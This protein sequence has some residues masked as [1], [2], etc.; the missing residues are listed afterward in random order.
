MTFAWPQALVALLFIPLGL[1]AYRALDRRQRRKV[2]A[3]GGSGAFGPQGAPAAPATPAG[4]PRP[5]PAR[6]AWRRRRA[7]EVVPAAL[8]L[9]GMTVMI[10]ALARPQGTINC[11]AI[12]PTVG[13]VR[14]NV[15]MATWPAELL[16]SRGRAIRSSN[17]SR[18]PTISR[19]GSRTSSSTTSAVCDA[20]MPCFL[21]FWP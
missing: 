21:N 11:N 13:R 2:A 8:L 3:F 5:S 9:L 18:P 6:P 10:V 15:F 4:T 20:R 17:F 19:P 14:S 7:R 1:L 16:P 12:A